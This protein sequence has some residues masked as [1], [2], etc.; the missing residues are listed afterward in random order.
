MLLISVEMADLEVISLSGLFVS[1][2]RKY[3]SYDGESEL[4]GRSIGEK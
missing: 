2:S 3:K 1:F 4:F